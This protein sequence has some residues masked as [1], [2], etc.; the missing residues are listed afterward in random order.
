M[1]KNVR[2]ITIPV[3]HYC[4]KARWTTS[5]KPEEIDHASRA[6]RAELQTFV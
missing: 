6:R 1:L 2:L 5:R 4:K 3:S